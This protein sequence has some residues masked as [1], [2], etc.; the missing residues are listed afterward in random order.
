MFQVIIEP[1]LSTKTAEVDVVMIVLDATLSRLN[2]RLTAYR[3]M[4]TRG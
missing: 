1:N 2:A 3:Q 4:V